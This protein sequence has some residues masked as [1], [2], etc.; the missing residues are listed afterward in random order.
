MNNTS[1]VALYVNVYRDNTPANSK[2]NRI[3][4]YL[5]LLFYIEYTWTVLY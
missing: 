3:G 5:L 2:S 1:I 4:Q